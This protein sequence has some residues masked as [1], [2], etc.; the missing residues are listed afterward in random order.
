[1]PRP[2]QPPRHQPTVSQVA[3][4]PL[5][6]LLYI[7]LYH[8][9]GAVT[10][11][12]DERAKRLVMQGRSCR[13]IASQTKQELTGEQIFFWS[14]VSRLV[15]TGVTKCLLALLAYDLKGVCNKNWKVASFSS[16]GLMGLWTL[17]A[18]MIA[19][20]GCTPSG[21]KAWS[22]YPTTVSTDAGLR[23]PSH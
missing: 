5:W 9:L 2:H 7:G 14:Q 11:N 19:T 8:G 23:S 10:R 17:G 15:S 4:T 20:V 1:M 12:T 13:N 18:P 21:T 3:A 22:P 6:I 16:L